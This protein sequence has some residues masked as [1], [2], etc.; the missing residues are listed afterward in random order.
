MDRLCH[1]YLTHPT[2]QVFLT[3]IIEPVLHHL[4]EIPYDRAAAQ[5]LLGTALKESLQLKYRRQ[6]QGPALGYY[7]MEP[8][9]H[10]DIWNN[11]GSLVI[12]VVGN[13]CYINDL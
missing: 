3:T 13:L 4:T 9:T 5:L 11:Y 6:I 8:A 12:C 7:Q 10:D 2:P 1:K